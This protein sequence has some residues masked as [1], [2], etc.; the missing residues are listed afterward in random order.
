MGSQDKLSFEADPENIYFQADSSR[1]R[2]M[3][4]CMKCCSIFILLS[5]MNAL[6]FFV[7]HYLAEH[8]TELL[9]DSNSF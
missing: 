4:G 5:G 6:S 1:G 2:R 7:G 8:D 3:K 9:S